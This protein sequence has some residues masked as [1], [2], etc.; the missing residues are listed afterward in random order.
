MAR[1]LVMTSGGLDSTACIYKLLTETD[2]EL[3]LHY[4]RLINPGTA[5]KVEEI[6]ADD[7]VAWFR[8][9]LRTDLSYTKST[10]EMEA[11]GKTTS[12]VTTVVFMAANLLCSSK[13]Y[14]VDAI[15][16][17]LIADD[18]TERLPAYRTII[19]TIV[20]IRGFRAAP[21]LTPI[22]GSNKPEVLES[23]PSELFN[24]TWSCMRPMTNNG[25]VS[26]CGWCYSC[27]DFVHYGIP[28]PPPRQLRTSNYRVYFE[29]NSFGQNS[30]E[31]D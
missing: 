6:A 16:L 10:F 26:A 22:L 5:W 23:I 29:P 7:V 4:V 9:N 20:N 21:I 15:V 25:I 17:G 1:Y 12:D 3:H 13:L 28:L 18:S 19:D 30:I 2:H 24:L 14:G 31:I 8:K 27:H 11:F